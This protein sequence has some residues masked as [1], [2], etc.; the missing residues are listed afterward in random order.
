MNANNK[1]LI[2]DYNKY[3]RADS[4]ISCL[5]GEFLLKGSLGEGMIV[6]CKN[7]VFYS[8]LNKKS[9]DIFSEE[10][11]KLYKS[12]K[13]FEKLLK[14]FSEYL[15]IAEKEI[16]P[17][18]SR[19][20]EEFNYKEFEKVINF[21][22]KWWHFNGFL[23]YPYQ[24]RIYEEFKKTNNKIIENN[25][26][27]AGHFKLYKA[28]RILNSYFFESGTIEKI[29]LYFNK[30]DVDG[31]Y[32]F[33]DELKKIIKGDKVGSKFV[34]ERK[35]IYAATNHSGKIKIFSFKE[36]LDI[37]NNL[38]KTKKRDEVKGNTVFPGK[39]KGKIVVAPM[40][41]QK[42]EIEKLLKK[43]KKGSILVAESASI[44]LLPICEKVS[45]IVSGQGGMLSHAAIIARELKIPGIVGAGD[46]LEIFKD[47]DMVEVDADKGMVRLIKK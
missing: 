45:A 46:V 31:H 10:G 17:K 41:N 21:L 8:F 7:N 32:L 29:I 1:L 39:V 42:S 18:Y 24:K 37:Y 35:K 23:E 44:E 5:Q 14:E 34:K 12:K 47:G 15:I 19:T 43:I 28:R 38:I 4:L 25:L 22:G 33:F 11:Y 6:L 9:E 40:L 36:S 16:I 30:Y 26:K 13:N 3:F 20:P 2:K 27:K